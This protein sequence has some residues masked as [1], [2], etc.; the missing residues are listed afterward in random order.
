MEDILSNKA[1]QRDVF[2]DENQ[3][4]IL[5][6]VSVGKKHLIPEIRSQM[7]E[8][9]TKK[10]IHLPE[11]LGDDLFELFKVLKTNKLH[12]GLF[13][14]GFSSDMKDEKI[15]H[16]LYDLDH[17]IKAS[18]CLSVILFS[19]TDLSHPDYVSLMDNASSLYQNVHKY[20][21]YE[22]RDVDEFI[23]WKCKTWGVNLDREVQDMIKY[24]CGGYLWL[25]SHM[26]R[27]ARDTGSINIDALAEDDVFRHKLL[28]IWNKL[29]P[30]EQ[31]LLTYLEEDCLGE[32]DSKTHEFRYLESIGLVRKNGHGKRALRIPVLKQVMASGQKYG[33]VTIKA[34]KLYYNEKNVTEHYSDSEISILKIMLDNEGDIVS[35]DS[36]AQA[37]WGK[38]WERRYSDWS[39][40]S[41]IY[42]LRNKLKIIGLDKLSIKTVKSR[43]FKFEH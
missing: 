5:G 13:L 33:K 6:Y 20:Q 30:V 28:C 34:G 12:I 3:N 18:G 29:S 9:S 41:T 43:G 31:E 27:I 8:L 10:G 37:I 2:G 38:Y 15:F 21:L 16:E 32:K 25:A 24:Q 42:R 17:F 11:N 35:R 1:R 19:T 23:S 22:E 26:L 7:F 4:I 36:I 39:I 40:D 14:F